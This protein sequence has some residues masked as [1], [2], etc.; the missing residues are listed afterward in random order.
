MCAVLTSV[1][2]N[3]LVRNWMDA[4]QNASSIQVKKV[5]NVDEIRMNDSDLKRKWTS[6]EKG[7]LD[8]TPPEV[9]RKVHDSTDDDDG[10][11]SRRR[12]TWSH[13][14]DDSSPAHRRVKSGSGKE[15]NKKMSRWV[16]FKLS[17]FMAHTVLS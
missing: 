8:Q 3:A 4:F 13:K 7:L 5:T 11:K 2:N 6:L 15:L 10:I 1:N 16:W 17:L 9:I 14:Q 12:L